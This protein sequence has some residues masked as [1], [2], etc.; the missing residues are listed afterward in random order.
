MPVPVATI[1]YKAI[2]SLM[3]LNAVILCPHPGAKACCVDAAE[4]LAEVAE[5]AGAPRV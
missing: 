2:I 3:T 5:A 4:Y 1:F